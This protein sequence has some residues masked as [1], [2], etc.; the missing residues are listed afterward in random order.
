MIPFLRRTRIDFTLFF[1]RDVK[2][3]GIC[4]ALYQSIY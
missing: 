2:A 4:H 1:S 3:A